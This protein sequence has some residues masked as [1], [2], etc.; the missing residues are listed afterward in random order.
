MILEVIKGV[1]F[2]S[3]GFFG[4]GEKGDFKYFSFWHFLPIILLIVGI[5]LTYIYREKIK[6]S[7]HEKLF[8]HIL[9]WI[10]LLAEMGYFWRVLY[11]GPGDDVHTNLL[12]KLPLQVCEWTCLFAVMMM[13]TESKHYFDINVFVSLTLGVVPLLTPAVISTTGPKYFRY[14]QFWLEHCLP[15]YSV[16]YMIFIKGYKLDIKKIYKPFIFLIILAFFAVIAN[17]NIEGANYLY[18]ASTTAGDS[19]AN[20]LP[21]N[22]LIRI[23]IYTGAVLL[24]FSLEYLIFKL[25]NYLHNKKQNKVEESV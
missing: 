6:N 10:M 3:S 5:V 8:R 20:I 13:L 25:V 18:L 21:K 1:E 7:K 11:A 23:L 22:I 4:Y 2:Y 15:I 24:L 14:Y 12:T 9:A 19:I 16:F 17:S